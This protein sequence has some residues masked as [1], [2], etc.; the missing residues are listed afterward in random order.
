MSVRKDVQ[1]FWVES[2]KIKTKRKTQLTMYTK[3][4]LIKK[5]QERGYSQIES[6]RD[7]IMSFRHQNGMSYVNYQRRGNNWEPCF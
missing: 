3:E 5:M 6:D 1:S 7:Y 4:E 2:L